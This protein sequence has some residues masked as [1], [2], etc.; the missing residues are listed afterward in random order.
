MAKDDDS[1]N[2]PSDKTLELTPEYRIFLS[3]DLVGSTALKQRL[4]PKTKDPRCLRLNEKDF[5]EGDWWILQVIGFYREFAALF[6]HW[7]KMAQEDMEGL[8]LTPGDAPEIWKISGDEMIYTKNISRTQQI[9]WTLQAFIRAAL[10]Y[11]NKIIRRFSIDV[12]LTAWGAMFPIHNVQVVL[13]KDLDYRTTLEQDLETAGLNESRLQWQRNLC[14]HFDL[15]KKFSKRTDLL[16][17]HLEQS[18]LPKEFSAKEVYSRLSRDFIGPQIDTGFRLASHCSDPRRM[19]L[20]IDL[21]YLLSQ[22]QIWAAALAG[23][24]QNVRIRN[25][26]TNHPIPLIYDGRHP[27]KGVPFPYP[28]FW[29]DTIHTELPA[30]TDLQRISRHHAT[31]LDEMRELQ[32]A[33]DALFNPGTRRI[34]HEDDTQAFRE[35][36][37]FCE[38]FYKQMPCYLMESPPVVFDEQDLE[39]ERNRVDSHS[40]RMIEEIKKFIKAETS[41]Q[42][43]ALE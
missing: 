12:K 18:N 25:A 17:K 2:A 33:E 40:Y 11:R 30:E 28:V 32:K 37:R 5:E 16:K 20:S 27:F 10:S 22:T 41:S 15:L 39:H 29:T 6:S 38:R 34:P 3:I 23:G 4:G 19:P 36:R 26:L 42:G 21:V 35:I 7:W 24:E 14:E 43:Q 1:R 9:H 13:P 8:G 31:A